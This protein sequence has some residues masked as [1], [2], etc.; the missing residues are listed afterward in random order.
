MNVLLHESLCE[1]YYHILKSLINSWNKVNINDTEYSEQFLS[2]CNIFNNSIAL[3]EVYNIIIFLYINI[4]S[5]QRITITLFLI[6]K[7]NYIFYY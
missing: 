1:L 7:L 4:N 2:L 3:I 5:I 6:I